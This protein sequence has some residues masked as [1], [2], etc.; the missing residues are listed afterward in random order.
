MS[1]AGRT[2]N[3]LSSLRADIRKHL[4][5][6][7]SKPFSAPNPVLVALA[8]KSVTASVAIGITEA[9]GGVRHSSPSILTGIV[10]G[11]A[12]TPLMN[13][14]GVRFSRPGLCNRARIASH[15]HRAR[16][17]GPR[18]GEDFRWYRHGLQRTPGDPR[19]TRSSPAGSARD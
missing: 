18:R 10:G 2:M 6:L 17:L 9:L 15:R 19:S 16:V 4:A 7:I 5:I 1:I 12:V 8:P 14:L 11:I 3:S 13:L